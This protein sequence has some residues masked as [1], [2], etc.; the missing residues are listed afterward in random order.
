SY[1]TITVLV[2]VVATASGQLHPDDDGVTCFRC[3]DTTRDNFPLCLQHPLKCAAGE[4]CQIRYGYGT[5]LHIPHYFCKT[6]GSCQ[7]GLNG[8]PLPC[9]QGGYHVNTGICHECCST[10]ECVA[11]L[12]NYVRLELVSSKNLFCP[13]RCK[14]ND[15]QACMH[16]GR[17]C[18]EVSFC[19][20]KIDQADHITGVCVDDHL[21]GTCQRSLSSNPCPGDF[22]NA[23]AYDSTNNRHCFHDCCATNECLFPHFGIHM[24]HAVSPTT[25]PVSGPSWNSTGLW[26]QLLGSCE[27]T[28]DLA[29]CQSLKNDHKHCMNRLSLSMCP[30]TCGICSAVN[31]Y[32][33]KDT[34][35]LCGS[36][37]M[38]QPGF[39]DTEEGVVQCPTTCAKC[40]ELLES[41]IL[42]VV[43]GSATV[44]PSMSTPAPVDCASITPDD[45]VH[46]GPLC[47]TTFLGVLC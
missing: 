46:F 33:C 4:V 13:G 20:V 11:N 18:D 44:A 10:S 39:C 32:V 41:I 37:K 45:C 17:V 35:D 40:D 29:L 36:I 6:S 3:D 8:H 19:Q 14:L 43:D 2:L 5:D 42:S 16:T 15:V 34:S 27:D 30:K 47:Q 1:K 9:E 28:F 12:T 7:H 25:L 21:Y 24:A 22:T 26:Q 31:S 23:S 38:S